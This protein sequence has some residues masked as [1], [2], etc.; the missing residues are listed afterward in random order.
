MLRHWALCDISERSL[1][2]MYKEKFSLYTLNTVVSHDICNNLRKNCGMIN[3]IRYKGSILRSD[4]STGFVGPLPPC[5]S[6]TVNKHKRMTVKIL[7][8]TNT[9]LII[10]KNNKMEYLIWKR[11]YKMCQPSKKGVKCLPHQLNLM[12][13]P[14]FIW[15]TRLWVLPRRIDTTFLCSNTS[16]R[17]TNLSLRKQFESLCLHLRLHLDE[18]Q[19]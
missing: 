16:S 18:G 9:F 15:V 14:T 17:R 13:G 5:L 3:V 11:F 6:Y 10:L 2:F 1:C 19:H 12:S 7:F 8:V 4:L